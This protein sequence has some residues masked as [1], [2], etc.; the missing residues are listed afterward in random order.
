MRAGLKCHNDKCAT[1]Q[2]VDDLIECP[3]CGE[4][5][6]HIF[7]TFTGKEDEERVDAVIG[8]IVTRI[9]EFIARKETWTY[10]LMD[11]TEVRGLLQSIHDD[12]T[13]L[14]SA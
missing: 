5:N 4:N 7:F 6:V 12:L 14:N 8:G 13:G 3:T 2:I 10:E 11:L 9:D 1:D